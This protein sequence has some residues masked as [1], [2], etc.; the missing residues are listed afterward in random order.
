MYNLNLGG[1][2]WNK[3]VSQSSSFSIGSSQGGSSYQNQSR[4]YGYSKSWSRNY[5]GLLGQALQNA[6]NIFNT[7]STQMSPLVSQV[8]NAQP[9][10]N[11]LDNLANLNKIAVENWKTLYRP[12]S[13]QTIRQAI[14]GLA[15]RGVLDSTVASNVLSGI[16]SQYLTNLANLQRG[17]EMNRITEALNY[18]YKALGLLGNIAAAL[19]NVARISRGRSESKSEHG[20]WSYGSGGSS[21]RSFHFGQSQS[22]NP[23]PAVSLLSGLL[24]I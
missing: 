8:V 7:L 20:G 15:N 23:A 13:N 21:Q 14:T 6:Q 22:Y 1:N 16:A 2:N 5:S 9:N 24:G 10:Q 3:L 19:G 18:P 17:L 4:Q 12:T 11:V